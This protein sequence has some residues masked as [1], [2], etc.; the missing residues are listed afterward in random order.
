MRKFID[1]V[2]WFAAIIVCSIAM[3]LVVVTQAS[4]MDLQLSDSGDSTLDGCYVDQAD[5]TWLQNEDVNEICP[6]AGY[7]V[8]QDRGYTCGIAPISFYHSFGGAFTSS[9]LAALDPTDWTADGQTPPAPTIVETTCPEPPPPPVP[10]TTEATSSVD[11]TEQNLWN[12]YFA[13]LAIVFMVLWLGRS[14]K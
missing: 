5:G 2:L 4:A 11:Q 12:A 8:I 14:K 3:T 13:F 7:A 1:N 10:E 6:T 9:D